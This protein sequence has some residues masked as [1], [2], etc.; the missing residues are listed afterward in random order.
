MERGRVFQHDK[1]LEWPSL[2]PDLNPIENL[3][4]E[5]KVC[6]A[7]QQPQNIT[8]LE[9][10]CMEGWAR[11]QATACADL[12]K[13]Y[14]KRL[15]SVI[16]N[17]GCT[18]ENRERLQIVKAHTRGSALLPCSC[19]DLETTF[20]KFTWMKHNGNKYEEMSI[21]SDQYRN[22]VQL[23]NDHSPGNLSLLISHLTEE[24]KG[25][26]QCAFKDSYT[27]IRLTIEEP[28]QSLP[29]VPFALVTVILLHI[30]VAVVYYTSRT[31]GCTLENSEQ[32]RQHKQ[33][34]P[35]TAHTGGSVLLPCY[36]TDLQ[37]KPKE[38]RWK[39]ANGNTWVEISINSDQYRNRVQLVNDHSPG[40]LSLLI[41]HLT[42]EDGGEYQCA[43]KGSHINIRLTF[44]VCTLKNR[45]RLLTITAPT[46][47]SV[48]LPCSC[49]DLQTTPANFTWT[50]H[51]RNTQTWEEISRKSGQY[52]NRVQL[53]NGHSPGNLSLLISHLT[54]E[55][56]GEYQCAVKDSYTSIRLTIEEGPPTPS[57]ASSPTA[58]SPTTSSPTASSPTVSSPTVSSPTV[59]S[60]AVTNSQTKPGSSS[61]SS[62]EM[63]DEPPPSLPFIPFGLVTVILLHI[64]VAVVYYTSRTKGCTL[65]NRGQ[66]LRITAHTGG[67][68]LLP[69]SC[70]D[71]Q[72]TPEEF[73]WKKEN[74]NTQRWEEISRESGQY[75][76]RV[77]LFNDHSPGNLSLLISHL[78]EEDGGDYWCAVK[79]S[80][81][82][83]RLTVKEG[84]PTPSTASS[85][86]TSSPAASS[87]TA[88]SPTTSSP[89]A[90]SP[91]AS[92]PT[93]SSPAVTSSQTN[94]GS[95]SA[96][97]AEMPD[98][99]PPSLPFV[100]FAL[101]TV[102]LLHIIVAVVY[103]TS[104]T[105][106]CTLENRG[107]LLHITAHTG[108]SVLLPCSCTDLQTTPEEFSWKKENTNTQIYEEISRESGQYRNRVQLVNDHSPG[109][110]SLLISHL[111]E[112]DG[113]EY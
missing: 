100:P 91:T 76:N 20:E 60:P 83:I 101:V 46:G 99:P 80:Y 102:I 18:L 70:T 32:Q 1:V 28:P 107:Q 14:R 45:Q 31:K 65:E 90:S 113:G 71:L 59:S 51:I 111:T 8:A 42:E 98:E 108:G 24:D 75:R 21:E 85:P 63:P 12:V 62:A 95:S 104:R 82:I 2:S 110:L 109:N 47:E 66:L 87:P 44:Q 3:W 11:I 105:K 33:P 35:I 53:V 6:V 48:L 36:C 43:V 29:F 96:S 89:A 30:I 81:M 7:Q 93:A 25:D 10:I 41:S 86:T 15:T 69:C 9:E 34:L 49:T 79:G 74:T 88:S 16:A 103:Y 23:F 27:F 17:K 54:E 77:Q 94:P 52:R 4:R 38:F 13:T 19:P 5:L 37:T 72:T 78:T 61:A 68:V 39:R 97:S 84:P 67:S 55:D 92:S 56:G 106:G 26:Y 112:E 64:I 73:S 57:T 50:K 22:R 58:S 40:N